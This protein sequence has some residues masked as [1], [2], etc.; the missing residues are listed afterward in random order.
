MK[1]LFT[2]VG[3]RVELMQAFRNAASK[4]NVQLEIY[5]ADISDTAPALQFCDKKVIVP[6]ITNNE[7]IPTLL[8][9][10]R[11]ESID[12]LIPTIDTDLLILANNRLIFESYGTKVFISNSEKVRI[13]RDKRCTADYFL[14]LG[15][16]NPQTVDDVKEYN[17]GF[18]AFIKPRDGSSSVNAHRID[19]EQELVAYS[20]Q[21][22]DYIIQPFIDG[23]EYTVDAFCDYEGNPILITPRIRLAVRAG[24]VLKTEIAQDDIIIE[25]MKALIADFKPRGQ[26]TVQLIKDKQTGEN[27]YI[28]INPRF[29]G[30]APL[31]IKAGADSAEMVIRILNGEKLKYM[32]KAA[33]DGVVYSRFDQSICVSNEKKAYNIKGIVFDLDDTL[34]SEKQYIRSGY[35]RIGNYLKR[36]DA[37]DIMWKYF[38]SGKLAIDE[39]LID[40]DSLEKKD[41]CVKIY[42]EQ[43][44]NISLYQG[45]TEM[46]HELKE[47]GIRI[48]IIT[49]GRPE[50]QKNKI[51]ALNLEG[52]IDDII[53][54]DE[55]GGTQFRKPCDIAFRIMK[56]R[57]Q[58]SYDEMVYVG[59]NP[60][61]D[62]QAPQ[63]LGMKCLYFCNPDGLYSGTLCGHQMIT[64][65]SEIGYLINQA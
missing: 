5:G 23:V 27:Y 45:V 7:Y 9:V 3:R 6:R 19:N 11:E 39:Y 42:R 65:L 62:F 28:E 2:S 46:L 58:I 53:I 34:Y 8:R 32:P 12:A 30:G 25:E 37:P 38:E 16:K 49:D 63:Q 43:I 51:R 4:K 54:T 26:I 61:K 21:V 60:T 50:G 44:P 35:Q 29:G 36:D 55:L 41:E 14:S 48:G 33:E 59:D 40:I 64:S 57:W 1:I 13:C 20:R 52:L 56:T 18:P 15:L 17:A 22:P 10:C 24:E 31:S 47:K